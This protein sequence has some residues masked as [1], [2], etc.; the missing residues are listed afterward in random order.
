[1]LC[2]SF[3]RARVIAHPTRW[4][5]LR[6]RVRAPVIAFLHRRGAARLTQPQG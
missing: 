2:P 4:E 1:V 6:A 3:Y 5:R